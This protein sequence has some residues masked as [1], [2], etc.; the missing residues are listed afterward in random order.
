MVV[1]GL[2]E[3]EIVEN[4][5]LPADVIFYSKP[6]PFREL[7]GYVQAKIMAIQRRGRPA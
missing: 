1:S 3:E 6:V 4:G 5:G 7:K 2:T